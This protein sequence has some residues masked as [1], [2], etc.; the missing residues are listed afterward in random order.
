[1]PSHSCFCSWPQNPLWT[2]TQL[3]LRLTQYSQGKTDCQS[4]DHLLY[5]FPSSV[6]SLQQ[7]EFSSPYSAIWP[8]T[9]VTLGED[10]HYHLVRYHSRS[11]S[12][13][14]VVCVEMFSAKFGFHRRSC[15]PLS[16]CLHDQPREEGWHRI[17][18]QPFTLSES[19]RIVLFRKPN[20]PTPHLHRSA[21]AE[22][23]T[24][25]AMA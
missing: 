7:A 19:V 11:L 5:V 15:L 4:A 21:P 2:A 24:R 10:C 25:K 12:I 20:K 6:Q 1:M 14:V 16:S 17:S 13:T 3:A 23:G 8:F 22:R 18:F 9:C